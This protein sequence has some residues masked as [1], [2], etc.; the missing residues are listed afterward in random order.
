MSIYLIL[1]CKFYLYKYKSYFI[2]FKKILIKLIVCG[3][4][5][6]KMLKILEK[7][8]IKKIIKIFDVILKNNIF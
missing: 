4:K 3:C 7:K 5:Y 6:N 2:N 8:K 1:I